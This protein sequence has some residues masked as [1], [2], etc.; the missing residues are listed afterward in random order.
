[1]IMTKS[2]WIWAWTSLELNV[3]IIGYGHRN[4]VRRRGSV[5]P[6]ISDAGTDDSALS[7][8]SSGLRR[9]PIPMERLLRGGVRTGLSV[10]IFFSLWHFFDCLIVFFAE[11]Q[12]QF[13]TKYLFSVDTLSHIQSKPPSVVNFVCHHVLATEW[14]LFRQNKCPGLLS[15]SS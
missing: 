14:C 6:I 15:T 8:T 11:F 9:K 12:S 2:S 4:R 5:T 7:N 3:M 1:M 13:H 10:F